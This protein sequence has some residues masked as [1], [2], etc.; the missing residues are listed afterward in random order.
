MFKHNYFIAFAVI[1][2]IYLL[3]TAEHVSGPKDKLKRIWRNR[4]EWQKEK[5]LRSTSNKTTASKQENKSK[6]P[7]S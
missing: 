7:S 6:V 5:K 2:C 4:V 3:W 1:I